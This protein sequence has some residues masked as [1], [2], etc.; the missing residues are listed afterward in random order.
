MIRNLHQKKMEQANRGR[1]PGV[2]R[3]AA[4]EGPAVE[5]DSDS[6]DGPEL[7]D[8]E[9]ALDYFVKGYGTT[10]YSVGN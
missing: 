6:N 4:G 10:K 5:I 1:I 2:A 8:A 3:T 9:E 7:K